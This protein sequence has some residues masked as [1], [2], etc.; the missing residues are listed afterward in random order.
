M[1]LRRLKEEEVW[2]EVLDWVTYMAS[3]SDL[4]GRLL[5]RLRHLERRRIVRMRSVWRGNPENLDRRYRTHSDLGPSFLMLWSPR[6]RKLVL[7]ALRLLS[8]LEKDISRM[9]EVR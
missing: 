3:T 7:A 2:V 4:L 8:I 6:S 5:R 1:S 9:L